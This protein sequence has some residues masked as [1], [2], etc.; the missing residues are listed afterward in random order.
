LPYVQWLK[1]AFVS[2]GLPAPDVALQTRSPR[3]RL[4]TVSVTQLLQFSSRDVVRQASSLGIK[5]LPV[6][7]LMWRR[8]WGVIYREDGYVSP[9]AREFIAL[10]KSTH[11]LGATYRATPVG[12]SAPSPSGR[13]ARGGP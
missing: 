12:R 6:R 13:K 10:V 3:L 8:Q 11:G 1:A 2:R 7:E 4:Q 5:E 9:L